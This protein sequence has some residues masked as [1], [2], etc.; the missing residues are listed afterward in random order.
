[1]RSSIVGVT[2]CQW[3]RQK[4]QVYGGGRHTCNRERRFGWRDIRFCAT[5][6]PSWPVTDEWGRVILGERGQFEQTSD[7]A[8]TGATRHSQ[9]AVNKRDTEPI[10]GRCRA[11][12]HQRGRRRV[13][14]RGG[15]GSRPPAGRPP[16]TAAAEGRAASTSSQP[17]TPA[18][19]AC[20]PPQPTSAAP[21][22]GNTIQTGGNT[23]HTDRHKR[24]YT[25]QPD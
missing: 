23:Q 11:F 16:P 14:R 3:L 17:G 6:Y 13:R 19:T 25:A 8:A 5:P 2:W 1:M 20:P 10:S 9:I 24:E 22:H 7:V 18:G 12:N 4:L 21:A 15:T